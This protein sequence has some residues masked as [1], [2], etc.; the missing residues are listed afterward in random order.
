MF[1]S[2]S[3]SPGSPVA[4]TTRLLSNTTVSPHH[5][6]DFDDVL[7]NIGNGYHANESGLF[8]APVA[9][10]YVFTVTISSFSTAQTRVDVILNFTVELCRT[11][12]TPN[13]TGP[14][15]CVAVVHLAVGDKVC[16]ANIQNI[17]DKIYGGNWSS[18]S[19]FLIASD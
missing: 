2:G 3:A 6:V 5:L 11:Y 12:A 7:T 8:I 16:A 13:A 18:F 14:G 17:D 1:F 9:G 10:V 19:G 4:F 15:T